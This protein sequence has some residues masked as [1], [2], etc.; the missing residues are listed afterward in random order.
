M[1]ARFS[2]AYHRCYGER[3]ELTM[4][5]PYAKRDALE[6]DNPKVGC[7][8]RV[9]MVFGANGSGKS[10][11]VEAIGALKAIV[12]E[13][14]HET[15]TLCGQGSKPTELCVEFLVGRTFHE[16]VIETDEGRIVSEGLR[17]KKGRD[18]I[19][20][21]FTRSTDPQTG[22]SKVRFTPKAENPTKAWTEGLGQEGTVIAAAA[23]A[24]AP[25]AVEIRD[26]FE[27]IEILASPG[28]DEARMLAALAGDATLRENVVRYLQRM[29]IEIDNIV[30]QDNGQAFLGQ[31]TANA[32]ERKELATTSD[33]TRRLLT[34]ATAIAAAHEGNQARQGLLVIDDLD[35]NLHPKVSAAV[36]ED[37]QR[38]EGTAQLL[39]TGHDANLIEDPLERDEVWFVEKDRKSQASSLVALWEYRLKPGDNTRAGYLQGRFGAVPSV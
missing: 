17:T 37:F 20:N 18:R 39:A 33:G 3:Q 34:I 12:L 15:R 2:V 16:Y 27:R 23:R 38:S 8:E 29:D 24:D 31:R 10:T 28:R 6:T 13:S 22:R 11:L 14:A 7:L 25:F 21:V 26:W 32:I 1:L 35:R 19:A 9:S 36:I 5:A 4:A 30:V